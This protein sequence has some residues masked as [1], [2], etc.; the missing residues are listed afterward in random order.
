M[1]HQDHSTFINKS[2]DWNCV[3]NNH[4]FFFCLKLIFLIFFNYFDV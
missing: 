3:Q 1:Q 2:I 4:E